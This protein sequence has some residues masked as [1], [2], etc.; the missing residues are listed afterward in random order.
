MDRIAKTR[1]SD[2]CAAIVEQ[3]MSDGVRRIDI[4][5][6]TELLLEGLLPRDV[7][8][9][10]PL[11][12]APVVA[13]AYDQFSKRVSGAHNLS[14]GPAASDGGASCAY[15]QIVTDDRPFVVDSVTGE[16]HARNIDVKLALHPIYY[17]VRDSGGHL[18]RILSSAEGHEDEVSVE[19][20]VLIKIAALPDSQ[21][22]E[23]LTEEIS[24]ILNAVETVVA[25]WRMMVAQL[26]EMIVS[27]SNLPEGS[28]VQNLEESLAFLTW[29]KSDNFTFLGIREFRLEGD[30]SSEQ[31]SL[32]PV[33]G[34]GL[35]I[36]RDSNVYVLRRGLRKAHMTPEI[37]QFFFQPTP[38]IVTKANVVS[39]VHRRVHMDYIGVKIY[40]AC[41]E[42]VGEFR[43]VGLFTSVAYTH[44]TRT[45]PLIRQKV[46]YVLRQSGFRPGGHAAKALMNVLETYP[47]S[48]LYQIDSELLLEFT[49]EIQ[50][51][52]ERPMVRVF[53]RIDEFDRFVSLLVFVPR[54]RF[55][56]S[57]RERIGELLASVYDGWVSAFFPDFLEGQLVRIHFVIGRYFGET[58][59]PDIRALEQQVLEITRGWDDQLETALMDRFTPRL[60]GH[61][62]KKYA[63][64]FSPGFQKLTSIENAIDA[65]QRIERLSEAEPVSVNFYASDKHG[66]EFVR[67][68]LFH[69]DG[70][71]QLSRR[72]PTFENLGFTVIEEW[73]DRIAVDGEEIGSEASINVHDMLLVSQDQS[74]IDLTRS[75][76]ALVACLLATWREDAANDSY[77]KLVLA[78]HAD[79]REVAL[80]RALGAYL[81][82]MG[83]PFSQIYLSETLAKYPS[84]SASLIELF[85]IRFDPEAES[86]MGE[87]MTR[88]VAIFEAVEN[89][90]QD[91]PSLDEDRILRHFMNLIA[92]AARTNF[93]QRE[94]DGAWRQTIAFKFRSSDIDGLPRP[95]PFAEIFVYSPRVEGIHLR[96]G[97]VARGGLRWSD[98]REDFR[99]EVLG[100]AKAQQVKNTVIVPKGSKGGFVP[101][102]PPLD[103]GREAM[104]EEGVACYR[105]F[106]SSLLSVTDNIVGGDI[107]SPSQTVCHDSEDPYLVVAADKGTAAF[108]DYANAISEENHF[109]LGDAF[110]SG[111]SAGYDHKKMGITAR[112]AWEAVKRHFREMD[113]D[114]QTQPTSVIGVGDMSGDVFGNGMLLSK[115]LKVLAAF[116]HRDIFVD[117]DPDPARSWE[118]RKRLFE[119]GR[120]SWRDYDSSVL[121]SGGGI[122]SRAD[123]SLTL[124]DEIRALLGIDVQSVSPNELIQSILRADADLLW[125]GGIGTYVRSREETNDMVGDRA[126]DALRISADELNVK[127][128]G[129]GA[130]LGMTQAARIAFALNGGRVNTDAIDNSA[131]VNSS[132]LEVNIKIALGAIVDAGGET[133]ESRNTLLAEMTDEVAERCL[134]NNYLQ[135]LSISLEERRGVS[136]TSAHQRLMRYLESKELLDRELEGL[137]A[138]VDLEE[139]VNGGVGLTRPEIAVLL[140]YAKLDLADALVGSDL[141]SDPYCDEALLSYF[142]QTLV[143]RHGE[144]LRHHRL[145]HEIIATAL[146]NAAVN[147]GGATMVFRFVQEV[148]QSEERIV[149]A[150]LAAFAVFDLP[151]L[152]A[153]IDDADNQLKGNVQ[154]A[155]YGAVQDFVCQQTE[156]FARNGDWNLSLG[157][158]VSTYKNGVAE[159]RQISAESLGD[160][161][162]LPAGVDVDRMEE[163]S[164]GS[165]IAAHV[166][167]LTILSH[168][169]DVIWI[170]LSSSVAVEP[171]ATVYFSLRDKL[172]LSELMKK[173]A[174]MTIA[175]DYDRAAIAATN[176]AVADMFR[177]LVLR[178]V[179][180][181]KGAGPWLATYQSD[182]E[183][184]SGAIREILASGPLS[185]AKLSISAAALRGLAAE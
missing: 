60:A 48:E 103:G 167:D 185:V 27:L 19:S 108:S 18:Q 6:F 105:L 17:V 124:S 161:A 101:K 180:H 20:V 95:V 100:L 73:S 55:S 127:V 41:G 86:S 140:A 102:N 173:A 74:A 166:G 154:L 76:D 111:G 89:A 25:D 22:Y 45:L 184:A 67:V 162:S 123:K 61:F 164:A 82:Q 165:T 99:T 109:W 171:V 130:N 93:Y 157:E 58:P 141:L 156:W 176:E 92:A 54:N 155:L 183:Q 44:S 129:E 91:V 46:D 85:H 112:G 13:A 62:I 36:L 7:E 121:S 9:L 77:N 71:I 28:M 151:E 182:L 158:L 72:V 117:P 32:R 26:D 87:R 78:A 80:L 149:Q 175:D 131:G 35:G 31:A 40:G 98:R 148:G 146:T 138:D 33:E 30:P 24:N 139:R 29:L 106:I 132:D 84:I 170:S 79:W 114:I 128:V 94:A 178:C 118:E 38:L 39:K 66:P 159:F 34:S 115:S 2:I 53:P 142:P 65:I 70:P 135:S 177:T 104:L 150:F 68:Q 47:R 12:F 126:N 16:L 163:G 63:E 81:Q 134:R 4:E 69:F 15:V 51:L 116:D 3:L 59:H 152:F 23:V 5:I 174:E 181:E 10:D 11:A 49:T 147:F 137:P 96:G 153:E 160:A 136:Q 56:T 43:I 50:S 144:S 21:E 8:A 14:V 120:S 97:P 125:F 1:I 172:G 143:D 57:V 169:T 107:V 42:I 179:S 110:A 122:F 64:A 90:L 75:E 168:A 145:K 133:R 88:Q 113:W 37:R 52:G 83:L 119:L